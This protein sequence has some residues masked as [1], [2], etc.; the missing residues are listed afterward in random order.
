MYV[1]IHIHRWVHFQIQ[2]FSPIG[3]VGKSPQ[4]PEGLH[5]NAA[6]QRAKRA[7]CTMAVPPALKAAHGPASRVLKEGV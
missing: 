2:Q 4:H 3:C 1:H 5:I 6:H 7:Y